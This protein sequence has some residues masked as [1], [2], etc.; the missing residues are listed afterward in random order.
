MYTDAKTKLSKCE[1]GKVR[2][3]NS[4]LAAPFGLKI[5][6]AQHFVTFYILLKYW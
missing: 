4:R 2:T 3:L 6:V 1:Q 5:E